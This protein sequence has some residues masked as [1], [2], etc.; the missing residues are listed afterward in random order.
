MQQIG[1]MDSLSPE[2][3]GMQID[4]H[5]QSA[6]SRFRPRFVQAGIT[7]GPVGILPRSQPYAFQTKGYFGLDRI[8]R[9]IAERSAYLGVLTGGVLMGGTAGPG[10]D[11][12][13]DCEDV[14]K[15]EGA[16]LRR[17]A[18]A[19]SFSAASGLLGSVAAQAFD[20]GA[21]GAPLQ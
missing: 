9:R 21:G 5:R 17:S 1:Q 6:G 20:G 4:D 16:P 19:S 8:R 18:F 3:G 11:G 10:A 14:P 7:L 15:F 12:Q 13:T 2:Q